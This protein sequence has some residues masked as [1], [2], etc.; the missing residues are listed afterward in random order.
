[1]TT[2]TRKARAKINLTLDVTGKRP[3]GYHTV[4]MVMQTISL[5]DTVTVSLTPDHAG[6]ENGFWLQT[7]LPYLPTDGR[8]LAMRAAKLFYEETGRDNPGTRIEIEKRIPV[9]A[10]LAGGSTDAA[11]VLSALDELHG[12]GL[13]IDRLCAMGLTL[14]AD[15]PYCLRGGTMLAEGIGEV[16]TPLPKMPRCTVVLCKPSFSVSTAAVYAEMNGGDLSP[17]PDTTG[18]LA[19]LQ[20]GDYA[21]IC[22]RLYN[23]MEPVTG[24]K[25]AEIAEIRDTLLSCGADGVVM[26]GSGPTTYGLFTSMDTAEQACAALRKRFPDTHLTEICD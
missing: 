8:N 21:G 1:M 2:V 10:G 26:S 3:D 11:A 13:D 17:R 4:R 20:A 22:H 25:H 5:H 15:V 18:M 12:T 7:N 23:V 16:L 9:A 14:G 19:A 6:D 24:S